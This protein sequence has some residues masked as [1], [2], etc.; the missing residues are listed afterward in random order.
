MKLAAISEIISDILRLGAGSVFIFGLQ[1]LK[2]KVVHSSPSARHPSNSWR[3]QLDQISCR[4]TEVDRPST[5][6]PF[7]FHLDCHTVFV[8]LLPS[9]SSF[10]NLRNK[11]GAV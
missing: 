11:L 3:N 9:I 1:V 2:R 6:R 8:Q 4:I 10:G 7:D 5:V